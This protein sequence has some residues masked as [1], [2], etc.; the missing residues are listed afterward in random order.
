MLFYVK[1]ISQA[2]DILQ[3]DK[4]VFY[5]MIFSTLPCLQQK[6][7][8]T[9][10]EHHIY[11]KLIRKSLL[12]S[13]ERR[14]SNIWSLNTIGADNAAI[15]FFS[16]VK[17]KKKWLNYNNISSRNTLLSIFNKTVKAKSKNITNEE[18][19]E[20]EEDDSDF[21]TL[22]SDTKWQNRYIYICWD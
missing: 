14:F 1:P 12:H 11:C 7:R 19:F 22:V 20:I 6:L 2:L 16:H 3:G 17:F 18:D 13:I 8:V 4:N 5:N 15:I 21:L 10:S 9:N